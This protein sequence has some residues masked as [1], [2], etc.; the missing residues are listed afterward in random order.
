MEPAIVCGI[1]C[2]RDCWGAL[3]LADALAAR[4]DLPLRVVHVV[5]EA[6]ESVQRE[7][8]ERLRD[9]I[10]VILG[11]ADVSVTIVAGDPVERLLEASRRAALLVIGGPR[12]LVRRALRPSVSSSLTR[13]SACPVI[14]APSTSDDAGRTPIA[15][16]SLLCAVRDQRD[17]ACA[18]TAACWARQLDTTL[19]LARVIEP[20]PMQPGVAIA[21]PPPVLPSTP[22]DRAAE[23]IEAVIRLA[24][25]IAAVGPHEMGTR[26]AFGTPHRQLRELAEGESACMIV[27]GP[28]RRGRLREAVGGSPTGRLLRRA[29]RPVMVCPHPDSALAAEGTGIAAPALKH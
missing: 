2:S 3:R 1:G 21:A 29:R 15:G 27:V 25:D 26:V 11:R 7:R 23:A 17:L 19:T 20:A 28:R 12:T 10:R 13:R 4:S 16:T 18:A 6:S 9:G 22:G 24:L 8:G 5:P 14:V